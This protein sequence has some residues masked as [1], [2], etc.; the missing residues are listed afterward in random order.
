MSIHD[1]TENSILNLVFRA[2]AWANYAD[3]TATSPQTNVGIA[4]HTATLVDADAANVSEV[5]Y[6]N[7]TRVNVSRATGG[8]SAAA[9]GSISPT[10]NIDF[11]VGGAAGSNLTATAFSTSSSTGSPPTGAA[12]IL[13][14][15][16]V[17]PSIVTGNGVTPRLTTLSTI[18][19]D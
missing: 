2:V 4:L 18:T 5:G 17:S 6:T 16:T 8:W 3:N 13:W 19:L 7:Y 15:G 10:A 11:P 14:S 1:G 9:G 12:A